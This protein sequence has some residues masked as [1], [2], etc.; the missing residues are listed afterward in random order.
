MDRSMDT[1]GYGLQEPNGGQLKCQ[2][3]HCRHTKYL[4]QFI[5]ILF[6]H[7]NLFCHAG[8]LGFWS[9]SMIVIGS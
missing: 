5:I 8:D 4:M 2:K 1:E 7:A 3:K 9:L 6:L